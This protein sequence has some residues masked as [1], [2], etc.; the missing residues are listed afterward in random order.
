M[1]IAIGAFIPTITDSVTG[2][3]S[4]IRGRGTNNIFTLS[5]EAQL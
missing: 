3:P 2:P 1:L 5:I 4:N